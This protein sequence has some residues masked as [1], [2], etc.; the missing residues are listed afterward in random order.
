MTGPVVEIDLTA[1]V[2]HL[3]RRDCLLLWL[4]WVDICCRGRSGHGLQ[5]EIRLY[6][7][8]QLLSTPA[9]R[10]VSPTNSDCLAFSAPQRVSM[11]DGVIVIE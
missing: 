10:P 5:G 6:T 1:T 7:P 8:N 3:Y 11:S 9:P 2:E 4:G